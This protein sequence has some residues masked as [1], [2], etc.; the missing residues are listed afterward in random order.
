MG[1]R[2]SRLV[3]SLV[4][5]SVS[6]VVGGCAGSG[7]SAPSAPSSATPV[8]SNAPPPK[9]QAERRQMPPT[10]NRGARSRQVAG[11]D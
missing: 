8:A 4:T 7:P 3:T 5:V 10:S 1:A 2:V 11:A 6:L 9:S